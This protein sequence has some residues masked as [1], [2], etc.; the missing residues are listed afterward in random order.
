MTFLHLQENN[1]GYNGSEIYLGLGFRSRDDLR[2]KG[3]STLGVS[4]EVSISGELFTD[5]S[6]SGMTSLFVQ[7]GISNSSETS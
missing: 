7:T 2:G 3:L 5:C 1:N 4:T 6:H